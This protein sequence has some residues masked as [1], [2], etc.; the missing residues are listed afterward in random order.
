MTI[1]ISIAVVTQRLTVLSTTT[2]VE[3]LLVIQ[4]GSL[5]PAIVLHH[6]GDCSQE[7]W[8]NAKKCK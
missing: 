2:A 5:N 6:G 8:P 3:M 4:I 7:E 1:P